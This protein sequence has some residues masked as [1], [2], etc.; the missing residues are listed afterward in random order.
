M[1]TKQLNVGDSSE[2]ESPLTLPARLVQYSSKFLLVSKNILTF[3]YRIL[4]HGINQIQQ[5]P[6]DENT[7]LKCLEHVAPTEE[8]VFDQEEIFKL[9]KEGW[10]GRRLV[11][12]KSD[13]F[14]AHPGD[15]YVAEKIPLVSM[16]LY[17]KD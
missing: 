7:E 15:E 11:L 16:D 5:E 9:G 12:T 10:Q 2:I 6:D 14:L 1:S 3:L 4:I 13:M 8:R 17:T